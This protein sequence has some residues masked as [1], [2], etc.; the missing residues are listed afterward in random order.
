MADDMPKGSALLVGLKSVDP[1]AYQGWNGQNGC[2]GCEVDVDNVSGMLTK[3]GFAPKV[4]KSGAATVSAVLDGLKFAA[5]TLEKGDLFVFYYSGHGGQQPD[6]NGDEAD[7]HDETLILFDRELI[8]DDLNDVWLSFHAGVRIVMISDSC[9]SG[10]N[11]RGLRDKRRATP[12]EAITN[13]IATAMKA[14]MIHFAGCRD[15][16]TSSGYQT[17]GAF[18]LSLCRAWSDGQFAGDYVK[19][20]KEAADDV[21]TSQQPQYNE[22]GAVSDAFRKQ[23]PFTI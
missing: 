11:Y 23:R 12:V 14:Q 2:W 9:T 3:S 20:F 16:A 13:E 4:L 5:R 22:Y 1:Q 19:L 17:G 7:G 10:T 6:L 18:T 21:G 15:A 8:D